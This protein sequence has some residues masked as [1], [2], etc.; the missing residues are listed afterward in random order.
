MK[1]NTALTVSA[2][3]ALGSAAAAPQEPVVSNRVV[4]T[5][6]EVTST[7]AET[8]APAMTP[9]T[10]M[11]EMAAAAPMPMSTMSSMV[12]SELQMCLDKCAP[13][14]VNCRAA[15]GTVPSP[16]YDQVV[17]TNECSAKCSQGSGSEAD[18]QAY[19]ACLDTCVQSY[20]LAGSS[21]VSGATGM[22]ASVASSAMMGASS[23][24]M[25]A[26]MMAS[27]ATAGAAS[28]VSSAMSDASGMV[29][30]ALSGAS[31]RVASASSAVSSAASRASSATSAAAAAATGSNAAGHMQVGASFAGVVGILAAAIAL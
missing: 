13:E 8:M 29:S 10:S 4:V 20:Y 17:A 1:V 6:I 5:Q 18:A 7:I 9:M 21:M 25:D 28:V 19:A 27:S 2:L 14:D 3:V 22:A 16:S 11:T 12:S 24:V 31:S 15:C 23:A 26:S 30:S